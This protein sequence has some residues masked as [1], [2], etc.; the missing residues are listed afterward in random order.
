MPSFTLIQERHEAATLKSLNKSF[1]RKDE[2]DIS[3]CLFCPTSSC[4]MRRISPFLF[5]MHVDDIKSKAF[6]RAN[7]TL[8]F[9]VTTY[10]R[11]RLDTTPDWMD[12]LVSRGACPMVDQSLNANSQFRFMQRRLCSSVL[13]HCNTKKDIV[14][15]AKCLY[16]IL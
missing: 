3:S 15:K 9:F 11:L 12:P 10:L 16:S 2:P 1:F 14:S 5:Y 7:Q 4:V 8:F 13:I 6:R